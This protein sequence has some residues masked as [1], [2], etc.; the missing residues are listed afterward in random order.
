M[1]ENPLAFFFTG[2]EPVIYFQQQNGVNYSYLY[3]KFVWQE[4]KKI[5][6][7]C[8]NKCSF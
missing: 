4:D 6:R 7:G 3:Q 5:K 2:K 8:Q 1:Q